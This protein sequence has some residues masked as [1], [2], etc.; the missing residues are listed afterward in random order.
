VAADFLAL[1]PDAQYAAAQFIAFLRRRQTP[2]P[3]GQNETHSSGT[4]KPRK[5]HIPLSQEPFVGMWSDRPEMEDSVAY[6]RQLRKR[7]FRDPHA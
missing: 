4:Q 7:E 3:A 5:A 2:A 6:I 1:P